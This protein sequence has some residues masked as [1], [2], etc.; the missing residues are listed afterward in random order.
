MAQTYN[1]TAAVK[2]LVS[3]A[4]PTSIHYCARYVA[5]AMAAGGLK[6]TRK[7]SAYMY[8]GELPR[9]GFTCLA[10]KTGRAAQNAWSNANAKAGDIAV[11]AHGQ[12]GHICMYSG[13][14]WISDF[15]QRNAWVYRA[16]G[17]V[18]FFRFTGQVTTDPKEL[19]NIQNGLYE[20][21][22]NDNSNINTEFSQENSGLGGNIFA[23]P[24]TN[25]Y[26]SVTLNDSPITAEN[27]QHTR[28]YSNNAATIVLDELSIPIA[29]YNNQNNNPNKQKNI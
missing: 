8:S 5:N 25:K 23:N 4:Q 12:H 10:T 15:K 7:A 24:G 9:I 22:K 16:E 27:T 3:N 21:T 11:M 14:Q 29:G 1:I 17:T 6:F 20:S 19:A 13:S 28:I 2:H 18:Q 26:S